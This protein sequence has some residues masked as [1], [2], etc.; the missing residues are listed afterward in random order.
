MNICTRIL[1]LCLLSLMAS[2]TVKEPIPDDEI[3]S[4]PPI[5][6]DYTQ[7]TIPAN[8][9]PLRF[10]LLNPADD[11]VAVISCNDEK[12]IV[13]AKDGSFMFPEKGWKDLLACSVGN[14]LSVKIYVKEEGIW[15]AYMPFTWYVSDDEIDRWLVYRL[16]N[17]GY[18]LW[19]KMGIYQRDLTTFHEEAILTNEQT[20]YNCMNCHSFNGQN[21]DM[22]SLHMRA[23]LGG[24]YLSVNGK[25]DKISPEKGSVI[26]S[27]VYPSWHPSGNFI[28]YSSN[29]IKQAFHTND[30]NRIEV[31][32]LSADISVY[33]IKKN[34]VLTDSLIA[35]PA[36]FENLPSFSPDGK[37]LYFCSAD[38]VTMPYDYKSV[39]FSLCSIAFD[40]ENGKFGNKVD[41]L[42]NSRLE[43]GSVSFPRV[44]PDGRFLVYTLSD[45]GYFSIWHKEADLYMIDLK[46]GRR[47][48]M[49]EANSDDVESY[50][51]W[52][53]NS[54]WM[55]VSSRRMDGLYTSPYLF[56][57]DNKGNCSKAFPIPQEDP[58]FYKNFMYSFNIPEFV[59]DRVALDKDALLDKAN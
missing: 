45:Y 43:N 12:M 34:K 18:E 16:I 19:N 15:N 24:T 2:C 27:F 26:N 30:D 4:M 53:S 23:K 49:V 17:P 25:I 52:S 58:S 29:D 33:D 38:S 41:T 55:V 59:K 50:H 8:I 54:K 6:P 1:G 56:H 31:Y 51:A 13:K 46:S 44:S 20:S 47:C 22:M 10:K 35:S 9:A 40:A 32:D 28:A 7:L 37:T 14:S 42:Y 3:H 48:R 5:F 39:K 11:A 21:P 36:V 57:I